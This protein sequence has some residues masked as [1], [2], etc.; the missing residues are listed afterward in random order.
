MQKSDIFGNNV[1]HWIE[2]R[3][4]VK[5]W[6]TKNWARW[7]TEEP[8]WFTESWIASVPDEF[9]PKEDIVKGRRRSSALKNLFEGAAPLEE[10]EVRVSKRRASGK[11]APD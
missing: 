11:V 2:I 3:G 7:K 5:D 9:I 4:E 10:G 8:E 6:T 1:R